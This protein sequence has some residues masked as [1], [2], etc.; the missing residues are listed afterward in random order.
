MVSH[1]PECWRK[2]WVEGISGNSGLPGIYNIIGYFPTNRQ[3]SRS[4]RN[5]VAEKASPCSPGQT[6][7]CVGKVVKQGQIIESLS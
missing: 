1:E 4:G 2:I 5:S 7:T 3:I 6:I